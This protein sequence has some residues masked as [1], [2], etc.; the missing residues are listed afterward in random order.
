MTE[1]PTAT[2]RRTLLRFAGWGRQGGALPDPAEAMLIDV[3]EGRGVG[4]VLE[5][6]VTECRPGAAEHPS[7]PCHAETPGLEPIAGEVGDGVAQA[8]KVTGFVQPPVD[9]VAHQVH[10]TA[11][12]GRHDGDAAGERLLDALAERFA[13]TRVHEHV[14]TG[15]GPREIKRRRETR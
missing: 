7:P 5:E 8:A 3:P 1:S 2:K 14:E 6:L 10:R 4:I 15:D 12:A 11:A 13:L 9:A